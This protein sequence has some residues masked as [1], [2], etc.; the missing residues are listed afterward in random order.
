MDVVKA[1][2][3]WTIYFKKPH[4]IILDNAKYFVKGEFR[5]SADKER[6]QLVPAAEY[7]PEGNGKL[8]E[9]IGEIQ[10]TLA[11]VTL[12]REVKPNSDIKIVAKKRFPHL[13]D[14][15]RIRNSHPSRVTGI[16][17]YQY[18]FGQEPPRSGDEL[19][20]D[21]VEELKER[22]MQDFELLQ[23]LREI[24]MEHRV[25]N[26][27][28]MRTWDEE[29]LT[30][31]QQSWPLRAGS[32]PVI[33]SADHA[34]VTSSVCT[35]CTPRSNRVHTTSVLTTHPGERQSQHNV[36]NILPRF[37]ANHTVEVPY[38]RESGHCPSP[39]HSTTAHQLRVSQGE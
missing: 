20:A 17:A 23:F 35:W 21:I 6:I 27:H 11:R 7:N 25:A 26:R 3:R 14:A 24:A 39:R 31:I 22:R 1:V 30:D 4:F 18:V 8:G 33:S 13:G 19:T 38:T 5:V 9:F 36:H 37:Q 15:L 2:R 34:H 10:Y 28:T 12:A 32:L 16:S 29:M